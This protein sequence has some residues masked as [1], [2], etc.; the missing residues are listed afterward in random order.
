MYFSLSNDEFHWSPPVTLRAMRVPTH[1]REIARWKSAS[2]HRR[3]MTSRQS[4]H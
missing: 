1:E 4:S 2:A 3:R